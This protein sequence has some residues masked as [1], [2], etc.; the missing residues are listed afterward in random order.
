MKALILAAGQ[1]TRLGQ[2]TA[3][4]PKPMLPIQGKPLL[5][6]TL[7]WLRH[8]GIVDIAINLRH[9]SEAIVRHFGTGSRL[10]VA[11]TY[12]HEEE[13]LGTAGA[14]KQLA[15][16]LTEPFVVVYGDVFTNLNLT[17]LIAFHQSSVGRTQASGLMTLALY[18]VSDPTQCGLVDVAPDG[19]IRRFVEK[20]EAD[21]VFTDLAFSGV[22]VCQPAI[23]EYIPL[24][25]SYDFGHDLLPRLLDASVPLYAQ[26][27]APAEY[28]VDIGTLQG[29]LTALHRVAGEDRRGLL[30]VPTYYAGNQPSPTTGN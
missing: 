3:N 6:Y 29:Y 10:G 19:Q 26:S 8:H 30:P 12:S 13:L 16:Y 7:A 20:P 28:V 14:A 5:E 24:S 1:G 15:S 17:R 21:Q 9:C 11:I 2:L 25:V 4:R 27:I 22:M 23:L 18:Q